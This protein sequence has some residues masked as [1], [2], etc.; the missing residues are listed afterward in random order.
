MIIM[1][2]IYNRYIYNMR[3]H[4]VRSGMELTINTIIMIIFLTYGGF[5]INGGTPKSFSFGNIVHYKPSILG[6]PHLWK[7]S[8]T[9]IYICTYIYHDTREWNIRSPLYDSL[10]I[11]SH[12]DTIISIISHYIPF[13]NYHTYIYPIISH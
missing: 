9:Y 7:P 4:T 13:M 10:Y 8:C 1:I 6:Y 11:D 12:Y 3:F 5:L 2:Y